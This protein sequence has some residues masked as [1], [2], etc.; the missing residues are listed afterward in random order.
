MEHIDTEGY[1]WFTPLPMSL[2]EK[3]SFSEARVLP[4][5]PKNIS[6]PKPSREFEK[7]P[8]FRKVVVLPP[9]LEIAKDIAKN[10]ISKAKNAIEGKINDLKYMNFNPYENLINEAINRH[11]RKY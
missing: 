1:P 6:K 8:D 9:T 10:G 4:K 7:L 11:L 2:G 3:H 5:P